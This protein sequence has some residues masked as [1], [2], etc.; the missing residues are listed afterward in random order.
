MS[1]ASGAVERSRRP[2]RLSV[3]V[4]GLAGLLA[5]GTASLLS[6]AVVL[7]ASA[8][9]LVASLTPAMF[10]T[11]PAARLRRRASL[12]VLTVVAAY[13]VHVAVT[14]LGQDPLTSIGPV[15]ALLLAGLA[16]AHAL[17]LNSRRDLMVGLTIG[18][19]MTVLAAGL[20]PGPAVA[21]PL[22]VGWPAAVTALVLAQRLE[23]F[24]A[25]H[26]VAGPVPSGSP[27]GVAGYG[28][29][30]REQGSGWS[31]TVRT[32]V[33]AVWVT[34]AAGL[35]IFLLLPQPNGLSARSRLLG[36]DAQLDVSS[37]EVRGAGFYSGGIMDL[38][39]RG[40]LSDQP[41]MDVPAGSPQ[42]W[43]GTVLSTYDGQSWY[44]ATSS[45]V[46]LSPGPV[47]QV[48]DRLDPVPTGLTRTDQV[49]LLGGFAG[50]V[51]APGVITSVTAPGRLLLDSD[52]G[53]TLTQAADGTA[54]SVYSVTSTVVTTD[55]ATLAAAGSGAGQAAPA[56]SRWLQLPSSLPQR[57]RDLSATL[58]SGLANRFEQVR[59]VETYLRT[60]ERYRLDSPVPAPGADAVDDFLFTS[61]AGFCEQFASAEVVLLRAHGVPARM[62][63]GLAYGTNAAGGVRRLLASDAHAWVEVWYPGVGWSASDP[64]AGSTLADAGP[65]SLLATIAHDVFD[66]AAHRAMAAGLVALALVAVWL[67]RRWTASSS[68]RWSGRW[69]RRLRRA[70]R[71][72][73]AGRA[74]TTGGPV[75]VAY[76]RLERALEASGRPRR[77]GETLA[78]LAVRLPSGGSGAVRTL[79]LEC[80]S[81]RLPSPDQVRAAV[82]TFDEMAAALAEVTGR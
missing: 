65:S 31:S 63:T 38:R 46:E 13:A 80:Y 9:F 25:G 58:T 50:S 64:T 35:V 36:T 7:A 33:G 20:A 26:P 78:E 1:V 18:L 15:L 57:V 4:A 52:G 14:G 19:F 24:E 16:L 53:L 76:R 27:G 62:V 75:L 82:A 79:E 48:P 30:E 17:V 69:S 60:H 74:G 37:A 23:Q 55:P 12:T 39:T 81:P 6:A 42:L 10:V 28:A 72:R 71:A 67:A 66:T 2:L 34:L 21:V 3:A 49:R 77:D 22:I 41:V 8:V 70:R 56:G 54:P 11:A 5:L 45:M 61:N 59:A 51:V 32:T 68:R 29:P 44:G 47:Y 73:A 40:T 43:R